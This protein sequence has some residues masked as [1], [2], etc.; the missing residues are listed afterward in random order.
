MLIVINIYICGSD[1]RRLGF[2]FERPELPLAGHGS[3]LPE[4]R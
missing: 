4:Q 2:L 3:V 1:K